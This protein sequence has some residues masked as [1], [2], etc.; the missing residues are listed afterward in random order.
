MDSVRQINGPRIGSGLLEWN[1]FVSGCWIRGIDLARQLLGTDKFILNFK[2]IPLGISFPVESTDAR[3]K[4]IDF[5]L[6]VRAS[7]LSAACW[8]F[9]L[10][11]LNGKRDNENKNARL[12]STICCLAFFLF[13]LPLFQFKLRRKKLQQAAES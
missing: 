9:L 5:S 11:S 4:F 7:Q 8:R 1:D 3:E 13:S 6:I 12:F 2:E 10:L